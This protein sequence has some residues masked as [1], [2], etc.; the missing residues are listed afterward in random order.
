M[1]TLKLASLFAA[2]LLLGAITVECW[3]WHVFSMHQSEDMAVRAGEQAN[4]LAGLRMNDAKSVIE[5]IEHSMDINVVALAKEEQT[6][7]LDEITRRCLIGVKV[8]RNWYPA[9]GDRA[10][11]INALL[12][13]IPGRSPQSACKSGVCR[14]D[15]LRRGVVKAN[16]DPATPTP[17]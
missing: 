12:E 14:L 15:D 2:G 13:K 7:P 8:Y 5:Q 1:N 17:K 16:T 4:W 10:A 9:S 3:S 6:A 11:L